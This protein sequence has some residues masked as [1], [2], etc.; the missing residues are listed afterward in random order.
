M[1]KTTIVAAV[2]AAAAVL[3]AGGLATLRAMP[4]D[5]AKPVELFSGK[6]FTGWRLRDGTKPAAGAPATSLGN[7]SVG[8]AEIDP[9]SPKGL[10]AAEGG[11]EM[12][13]AKTGQD[14]WSEQTFGDCLIE[15]EVM[16]PKGSNS[17]IYPMGL[18][19]IQV[20]DSFGKEK[21]GPGDMGGIYSA[22]AA[23]VNASKAPGEW[24]KYVID[25]RAPR[26]DADG[27]KTANARFVKV[28]LNGQVI[29]EDVEVKGPTGGG[30]TD[31]EGPA[32]P[33][34]FQGNHGPVAFR[35]IRITPAPSASA[36]ATA[37]AAQGKVALE[38]RFDG[39]LGEGWTWL[40]EDSKT[41][42]IQNNALEIRVEPGVNMTVKNALV[43]PAPDR[44]KGKFA[45]EVTVTNTVKPTNQF[46][47][48][49]ITWYK[50]GKP[51]FKLVKELVSDKLLIVPGGKPMDAETVQLR[52]VVTADS[53][54]AQYRPDA[55][56]EFETAATG[57]L[58][59]PG[60]DEVSIQCYN[61]PADAEHWIRFDDFRILELAE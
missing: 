3:G 7:W 29:H 22:A 43:R 36:A 6:D 10:K 38:D 16:V 11:K 30:V 56:G 35:S 1:S 31:K 48:A 49:G 52:L 27:K 44:A 20:L 18:Y 59:P 58:P 8:K 12:I 17:G 47:Q 37:P 14:I 45:V 40:R 5:A 25:F 23:K 4:A 55:K 33:L 51:V 28:T 32:G 42:R 2:A 13:S 15:L 60:K 9:D 46:E 53:W 24:Q 41:W 34:M 39:K 50:D 54:T 21:V 61:G 57:K 26:F 19:E